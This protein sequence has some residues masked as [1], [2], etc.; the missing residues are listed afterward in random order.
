[1][2][3]AF[4]GPHTGSVCSGAALPVAEGQRAL[5]QGLQDL[6]RMKQT[7]ASIQEQWL[8]MG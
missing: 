1:M 5:Y 8:A 4:P 7:L 3:P 6:R 2:G